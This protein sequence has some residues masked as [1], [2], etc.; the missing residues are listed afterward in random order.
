[1]AFDEEASLE[2]VVAEIRAALDRIGSAY[3]II[4]IDDGSTDATGA[5]ADR[6]ADEWAHVWTIHHQNNQGLGGVYRTGF[7]RAAHDLVTFFP[8]DGQFPAEIII[9]FAPR[10][11]GADMVLGYVPDR[12]GGMFGRALSAAERLLFRVLFGKMP[13]FQGIV[14]FR[15]A[16]LDE[17]SL[18][19]TGR[20]WVVLMELIL[21]VS[22]AGYRIVSVPIEMRPRASGRSKVNNVR[23]IWA[24]L[25]QVLELRRILLIEE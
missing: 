24:N 25:K 8:A 3:E 19:S 12:T 13:R 15:R 9:Q 18:V 6:L 16:L 14:M 11:P 5:I 21:R 7:A 2:S 20:G 23:T 4:V 1:M 17:V 22:R 10:F